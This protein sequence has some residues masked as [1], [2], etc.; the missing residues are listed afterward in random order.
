MKNFILDRLTP[1]FDDGE[2]GGATSSTASATNANDD[3]KAATKT[4]TFA[5]ALEANPAY[6]SEL[7]RRIDAAVKK[8][9]AN[10][11]ERQKLITDNLQDEVLRVSKM[12]EQEKE[13]YFKAKAENEAKAREADL[14]RRELTLDARAKLADAKLPDS[15]VN[16]LNYTNADA[17]NASIETLTQAFHDA[18]TAEV[19]NRLKG[20]APPKDAR[21]E[22]SHATKQSEYEAALAEARRIAGLKTK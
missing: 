16:L 1:Y 12:T 3:G 8:A 21:T 17:M 6:Q 7:D 22:G 14:T 9:T 18:V 2:A 5:E 4:P 15:F 13:A 11:R 20:Q 19:D 10:E